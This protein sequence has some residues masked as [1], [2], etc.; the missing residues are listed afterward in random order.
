MIGRKT[1]W[2]VTLLVLSVMVT[3]SVGCSKDP[4]KIS[5]GGSSPKGA[6]T[7]MG[8]DPVTLDP[9]LIQDA[10]SS[11]YAVEIFSGLVTF[12][13]KLELVPDIAE[14]WDISSDGTTYTF[15]L[16]NGVT[17]H[18]GKEVTANDFK[19]SIERAA[20]PK[21][22]S[23]VADLYL[24]DIVGA[25]EM[26]AGTRKQISGIKVIDDRTL[27]ITIDAPKAYFLA[28]LTYP[29][30]FVVDKANVESGRNWTDKPNGTGPFKLTNWQKSQKIELARNDN[31]YLEPARL[32]KII[33][34]LSGGSA[35]TMYENSELDINPF[36]GTQDIER[37]TDKTNPL[38]NELL[39][40]SNGNPGIPQFSVQ[41]IGFDVSRP[42]FD[43]PKVRQALS[44][45]I[46]KDKIIEV[47]LKDMAVK[48]DGILPPGMPGYNPS[49]KGLSYDS[50]KAKDLLSQSKYASS[51]PPIKLSISGSGGAAPK[52]LTAIM[53]MWKQN[54]GVDV[55]IEQVEF[56]TYLDD[57]K[58]H[59][60]QMYT[61]GWIAD[62]PDPQDFL[63]IMFNSQS[64]NNYSGYKNTQV[65]AL[66]SRAAVDPDVSKRLQMYQQAEQMI[67]DDAAWIPLTFEKRYVLVKPYVKGYYMTGLVVP[68]WK[69][70]YKEQS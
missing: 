58:A 32:E 39:L 22:A 56:A 27:S 40:D 19:Y 49:L 1:Y 41:Y 36:V 10:A 53:D 65:D 9:A 61:M 46:D 28:K 35:M 20:D 29:S 60:Y 6:L 33:F 2:L 44:H 67:V 12:N 4:G 16:R 51:M 52:M 7:V 34:L 62:Y 66:L 13:Q 68:T 54:L 70:V 8:D 17:F 48:A 30:A 21:T 69:Y 15:H 31:Y 14:R 24:N 55:Q 43:D 38:S 3:L 63:D 26:L 47:V 23:P 25:K 45:A 50:A 64:V 42:P 11:E 57:L 5:S 18:D 37:V 59:K